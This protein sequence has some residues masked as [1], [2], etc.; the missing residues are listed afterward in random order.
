MKAGIELEE[1]NLE[2]ID[3]VAC[4]VLKTQIF[5]NDC[6]TPS[7]DFHNA[8]E[9]PVIDGKLKA[10]IKDNNSP[11]ILDLCIVSSAEN[12]YDSIQVKMKYEI[13]CDTRNQIIVDPSISTQMTLLA[14]S[15]ETK[16]GYV[17]D[18]LNLVKTSLIGCPILSYE[19]S[20]LSEQF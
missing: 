2:P 8:D 17:F 10:L 12:N 4:T 20:P 1:V 16:E 9:M 13:Y 6:T 14:G 18:P 3:D 19:I 7:Q 5:E 11:R 15:P